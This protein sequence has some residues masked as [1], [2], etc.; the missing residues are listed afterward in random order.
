MARRHWVLGL[1]CTAC[2]P[3][4]AD[5]GSGR[6]TLSPQVQ[7]SFEEYKTH[8]APLYFV[9]TES[10]TG[11][12]YIY[13]E[14]GFGCTR[15]ITRQTALERCRR[16]NPGQDC[17]IYAVGRAVVWQDADA[18]RP[19]PQLSA[20]D[21]LTRPCLGAGTPEA[22]VD[23][24]SQAIAS[25]ALTQSEKR[26]ALYVRARAHEQLGDLD[27]AARDYEQVLSIDPG[28]VAARARL[29]ALLAPSVMPSAGPPGSLS[30]PAKA[31]RPGRFERP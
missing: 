30:P 26:G 7:A 31:G 17:K 10:G 16:N 3:G 12:F 23:A 1:L 9:V 18:P 28:H 5:F 13:C 6:I 8:D 25:A 11:S 2:A 21:Q 22:R 14:G 24:C 27:G 4:N 19:T 20:K 15:S 29:D